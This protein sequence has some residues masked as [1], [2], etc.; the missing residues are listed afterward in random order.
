[1][2]SSTCK[3]EY[4][5]FEFPI[6]DVSISFTIPICVRAS[7]KCSTVGCTYSVCGILECCECFFIGSGCREL[8]A[9]TLKKREEE[10]D[11]EEKE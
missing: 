2:E 10:R 8:L 6:I 1:M 4:Q 11:K 5:V 9:E 3:A 7:I